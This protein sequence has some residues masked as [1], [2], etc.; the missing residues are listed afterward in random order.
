MNVDRKIVGVFRTIDDAALVI[1]E[2]NDK[3]Y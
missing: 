2:L 3:G 1:N